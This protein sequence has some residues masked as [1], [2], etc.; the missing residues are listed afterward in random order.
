MAETLASY[1]QNFD[2][3]REQ[4]DHLEDQINDL[5]ELHQHEMTNVKQ[6]LSS[7]EEK[8]EYQLDERTRDM[9]DTLENCQTKVCL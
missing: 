8:M 3:E 4:F 1:R 2:V 6:E 9:Q 7:M 5:T